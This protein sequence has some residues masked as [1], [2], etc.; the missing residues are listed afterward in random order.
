LLFQKKEKVAV[1]V[2]LVKDIM[3]GF[4]VVNVEDLLLEAKQK[5]LQEEFPSLMVGCMLN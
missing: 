2:V 4:N 5:P 3:L 1:E